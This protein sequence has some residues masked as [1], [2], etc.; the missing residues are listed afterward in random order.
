M[1]ILLF[2]LQYQNMKKV[3]GLFLAGLMAAVF[4]AGFY[5]G[6]AQIPPGPP[7]G[8]INT[9]AGRAE[10]VDFSLFWEAW[11]TLEKEFVDKEKIDYQDMLYGA[12]QGLAGSLDDPHTVFMPPE[13][14]K[15]FKEDVSGEFQGVG[16]EIGI[17]NGQLTVVAPLKGTPA[18]RAGLR[19]GDK[20]I[21]VDGRSTQGIIIEEAVKLIRG[22]KGTEVMLTI[23]REGWSET[24]DFV[25]VRDVIEIPSLTWEL[26]EENIAYVKIYHF[27]ETAQLTFA[28]TA[29]EILN[30]PAEKIILD[31]RNNP[32]GYLEV[33]QNIAGWFLPNGSL[34]TIEDFGGKREAKEYRAR[35][36][37]KLVSYPLVVLIN[38]GSASGSEIL[39]GALRDNRGIK[40]IGEKSFGKGSVQELKE[41]SQGALKITVARWLTPKG[42]LIDGEG[43]K[44]DIE[45]KMTEEDYNE[46]RDPQLEKALEAI[47]EIG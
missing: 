29:A 11:R 33:A 4:V 6:K 38:Q 37:S 39:A 14:A 18:E 26:K 21:K 27:S 42:V 41:L 34:V 45:V 28:R 47:K 25:I 1:T 12:I 20:I 44:P 3:A 15:V 2:L 43:L 9:E 17:R 22:P 31:L 7:P 19:P 8:L 24:K 10:G 32:G 30:S 23:F 36:N 16:M 35:G 13:D 40:L 5:I 46:G